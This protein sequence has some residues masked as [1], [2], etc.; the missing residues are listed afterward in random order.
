MQRNGR[1]LRYATKTRNVGETN[2]RLGGW[3]RGSENEKLLIR[4]C[5]TRWAREPSLPYPVQL[6][7]RN[8]KWKSVFVR[9][10][11]S[12]N[13]RHPPRSGGEAN[14]PPLLAPSTSTSTSSPQINNNLESIQYQ[15]KPI[16]MARIRTIPKRITSRREHETPRRARFFGFL[17]EGHSQVMA[18]H[19]AKVPRTTAREWL[20]SL[21]DRRTGKSRP[22]RPPIISKEKVDEIIEWMTGYFDRRTLPPKEIARIHGLNVCNNT[23]L[24]ALAKRGYHYHSA[25][26]KPFLSKETKFKRW[27]FSW[28]N[29]DRL[30][31]YWRRGIYT[32]EMTANTS[33]R[34]RRRVLRNRSERRRLDCIQFTF[35]SGRRSV[36]CWAAIGYNFKSKLH[37]ISTEGEGKGFTQQKYEKQIIRGLLKDIFEE[38]RGLGFFCVEDSNTVHGKKDTRKNQGFC[39]KARVE[40]YILSID[41]PSSSP[42]LNPI[43]NIWRILKQL[44]R[45]R[46]LYGGWSIEQL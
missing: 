27:I 23:L 6:I 15:L 32:D 8:V 12:R 5:K 21:S 43:E 22:G 37:I 2:S 40:C 1:F 44:L 10:G 7:Y 45:N 13:K 29:W 4:S 41:W 36:S 3:D 38:R 24:S 17:E 42:D 14:L 26:S 18:A 31:W 9:R 30:V 35:H 28:A 11:V 33:I 46:K 25:N 34:R 16:E 20:H 19:M 39:N